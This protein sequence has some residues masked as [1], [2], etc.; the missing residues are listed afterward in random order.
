MRAV[1]LGY[2]ATI[3][4]A[5]SACSEVVG[6]YVPSPGTPWRA[7]RHWPLRSY[8]M[9]ARIRRLT[10]RYPSGFRSWQRRLMRYH[11]ADHAHERGLPQLLAPSVNS[12]RFV[13]L[14][15]ELKPDIGVVAN[16]GEILKAPV[17]RIPTHGF[18]NFH[19]SPLP[20]YRGPT[21]LP[22]MMLRGET[23][24]GVTWHKVTTTIDG[25]DILAQQNFEIPDTETV[26]ML[27]SRTVQTAADML[28]ALMRSIEQGTCRAIAQDESQS[29][30]YPKLSPEE[31]LLIKAME[32]R[33]HSRRHPEAA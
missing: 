12:T 24:G 6:V 4:D 2:E 31:K 7:L 17:L 26:S 23:V 5:L 13:K 16:F 8:A 25:G 30:Y 21:P 9:R 1:F 18:I 11:I 19:P 22:H 20:K 10:E 33:K 29:S 3:L 32:Q 28:P 14:L 15:A 27:T